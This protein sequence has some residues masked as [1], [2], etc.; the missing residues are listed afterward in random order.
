MWWKGLHGGASIAEW[1]YEKELLLLC[2]SG[3]FCVLLI[4]TFQ[5][6]IL[7]PD[8]TVPSACAA[9]FH[10]EIVL[11]NTARRAAELRGAAIIE[12]SPDARE[13]LRTHRAIS[14]S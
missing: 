2:R 10:L 1:R 12:E 11:G 6:L 8:S 4:Y 9:N 3:S 7:F 13:M 14:L 5:E